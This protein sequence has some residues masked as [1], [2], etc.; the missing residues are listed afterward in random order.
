MLTV[1]IPNTLMSNLVEN[2]DISSYF[3]T[4]QPV[5]GMLILTTK[6]N[7]ALRHIAFQLKCSG[8]REKWIV[9]VL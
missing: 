8:L 1:G 4:S 2:H 5:L 9:K 7:V 6:V 3:Y